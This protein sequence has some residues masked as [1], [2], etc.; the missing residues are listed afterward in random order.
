[1][2]TTKVPRGNSK[3]TRYKAHPPKRVD[4]STPLAVL[5]E[6]CIPLDPVRE[7]LN[8]LVRSRYFLSLL[9]VFCCDVIDI[10]PRINILH[11]RR[12]GEVA[13][14]VGLEY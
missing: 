12:C 5:C 9:L 4:Y 2:W 6:S 3:P 13:K 1:M 14:A 7:T 11:H 8:L 10:S